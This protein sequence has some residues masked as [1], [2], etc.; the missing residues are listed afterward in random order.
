MNPKVIF[1][2]VR[3]EKRNNLT[4]VESRQVLEQYKIPLAKSELSQ[5]PEEACKIAA[6][7]GYPVVLKAVS[8]KLIHKTEANAVIVGIR[9]ESELCRMYKVLISNVKRMVPPSKLHGILVQKMIEG[10]K[11]VI[12]GGKKDPQFGQVVMFGGGGILTEIMEDVSFRVC[13]ITRG[14]AED[15]IN[16]TKFSKVLRGYRG[17]KSDIGSLVDILMRTSRMLQEN[18]DIVEL[19][20]NPVMALQ[21]GA[22][23]VDARIVI[24]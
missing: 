3:K 5:T 12:I 9:N 24:G 21:E 2:K 20:I 16:E 6:K 18:Q 4:E 11:E 14:D 22:V 10:G 1:Q 19:D 7:L 8:P 13:P 15:M 23:A 17:K